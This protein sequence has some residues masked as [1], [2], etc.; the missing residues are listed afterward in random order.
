ML[1]PSTNCPAACSYCFGPLIDNPIMSQETLK[2][3]IIWIADYCRK[4]EI[5]VLDIVIHGGEPLT[6]GYSFY[7]NLFNLLH[8]N[9]GFIPEKSIGI[10]SNLWLIDEIIIDLFKEM[11]V[12]IGTSIDGPKEIC[13]AQRGDNYYEKTM[14]GVNLLRAKGINPGYICT[15]TTQSADYYK[16]IL[17]FFLKCEADVVIHGCVPPLSKKFKSPYLL[18][19]PEHYL[20]II[21]N[22]WNEYKDLLENNKPLRISTIDSLYYSVIKKKPSICTFMNC[23]G[24]FFAIS[25][26]GSIYPCQRFVASDFV[27]GNVYQMPD[28]EK[29]RKSKVWKSFEERQKKIEEIC[30]TCIHYHYCHGG[31]PYNA[32]AADEKV[33]RDPYC[34]AYKR[35]FDKIVEQINED[36]FNPENLSQI[37]DQPYPVVKSKRF[38]TGITS[39]M[40]N[41]RFHP[42][43]IRNN[44]R[45]VLV[46]VA[47]GKYNIDVIRA[48][49][50]K[51]T[52]DIA[53]RFIQF[54]VF[55]NQSQAIR[56]ISNSIND[57]YKTPAPYKCYI[58]ILEDCNLSCSHCYLDRQS[59]SDNKNKVEY[60][61]TY[62]II[63]IIRQAARAGFKRLIIT[64]GEPLLYPKRRELLQNL[65]LLQQGWK[66]LI[67]EYK[68]QGEKPQI[69][70]RTNFTIQMD[71]EELR[72]LSRAVD[73]VV[74]SIDGDKITHDKIRGDG[75]YS[76]TLSNLKYF[77]AMKP[78]CK[79]RIGS[80][81]SP[82]D[83]KAKRG[84][85][86]RRLAEELQLYVKIRHPYPLGKSRQN[87]QNSSAEPLWANYSYE[88]CLALGEFF[89]GNSCGIGNTLDIRPNGDI[90]PCFAFESIKYKIGKVSDDL[91]GLKDLLEKSEQYKSLYE[92][93]VDS[94]EQCVLC[95][96]R[97]LCHG[98]CKA[99]CD[100]FSLKTLNPSPRIQDCS[101]L[102]KNVE[103]LFNLALSHFNLTKNDWELI[104]GSLMDINRE[105]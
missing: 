57:I 29:L 27:M 83:A 60:L 24:R 63:N 50:D 54:G 104:L 76:L 58:H 39:K 56:T 84:E 23:L 75:T 72:L 36:F 12:S 95:E 37:V 85:Y 25:P 32:Y 52:L 88:E 98:P 77:L 78:K 7:K 79:I 38:R 49:K 6:V 80:I 64:G 15:F 46:G 68:Y 10:Q 92:I 26:D 11:D 21:T 43:N 17:N 18:L 100:D 22:I 16:K 41:P 87:K 74:V 14:R 96:L 99:W 9:L 102:F 51:I 2:K 35:F 13:N 86:I 44:A 5:R 97:Y 62:K 73:K 45:K 40:L 55:T 53:D 89:L 93:T 42:K 67:N 66:D 8:E 47:L 101:N 82:N 105:I 59:L 48:D 69:S 1:V 65:S 19:T 71:E 4:E 30:G 3:S 28:Q 31:C 20:K 34:Y 70:L 61:P 91:T 94:N 81:M 33:I 103:K 90:F